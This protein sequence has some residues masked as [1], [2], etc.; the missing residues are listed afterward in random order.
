MNTLDTFSIIFIFVLMVLAAIA[1]LQFYRGR[2]VN[3]KLMENSLKIIQKIVEPKDKDYVW[4]GGYVGYRA[5]YKIQRE[6]I[7]NLNITVTL[8]PRQSAFYYPIALLTSRMDKIYIVA[9]PYTKIERETHLIQEKYYHLRP[10]IDNEPLLQKDRVEIKKGEESIFY[11]A[12]FEKKDDAEKLRKFVNGLS[13][14]KDVKHVSLTPST[15]VFYV[16]MRLNINTLEEDMKH[17]VKFVNEGL[18]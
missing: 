11:N 14:P 17:I 18:P 2:K 4:L 1:S 10:H 8:I 7:D 9:Y 5:Y 15:N 16:F 13:N 6:N 12:L 3:V